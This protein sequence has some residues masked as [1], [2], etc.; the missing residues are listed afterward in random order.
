MRA[1]APLRVEVVAVPLLGGAELSLID[2]L[3]GAR[4]R[5]ELSFVA[6]GD[7]PLVPE[8]EARGWPVFTQALEPRPGSVA[9]A[10]AALTRR[11]RG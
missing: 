1:S 9:R 10:V 5:L 3:D 7:G 11:W 8:L 6:L 4:D 2:L